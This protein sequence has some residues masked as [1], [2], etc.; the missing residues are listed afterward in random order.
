[1][2]SSKIIVI[3]LLSL[4][5][6]GLAFGATSGK[7]TGKVM[8]DD[9]KE[10]A[11]SAS[12]LILELKTGAKTDFEG[13]Y[14]ILNIPPGTYTLR[15]SYVGYASVKVNNVIVTSG[16]TFTQN[17]TLKPEAL[18]REEIVVKADPP[19][20]QLDVTGGDKTIRKQD[21][22]RTSANSVQD[23]IAKKAGVKVDHEG[24]LHV[25]GGRR[26]EVA[27][28]LDGID[29]RDP[30]VGRINDNVNLDADAISEIN[31]LT[32][33]FSPEYGQALSGI[34]NASFRE[35]DPEKYTAKAEYTSDQFNKKSSFGQ[36]RITLFVSGPIPGTRKAL[37]NPITFMVQAT[38]SQ[39]NTYLSYGIHREPNDYLGIGIKLPE[40][41]YNNYDLTSKFAYQFPPDKSGG[42]KKIT[43]TYTGS[44]SQWDLYPNGEANVSGDYG[45]RYKFNTENRPWARSN[46]NS[47]NVQFTNNLSS[48]T[49]Y[50]VSFTFQNSR[51]LVQ[52][53]NKTPG[54]FTLRS[55]VEDYEA[56]GQDLN[57]DG[58]PDGFVDAN[59]DGIYSGGGH[60]Y[61]DVN[62][63]GKWDRGE[64]W[65]DLNS[66]GVYDASET[67]TDLNSNG[68]WDVGE[69]FVDLN[70]NA[71]W[72]PAEPQLPEQD[73]N[74]NGHWDGERFQDADKDKKFTGWNW[75]DKNGNGKMDDGEQLWGNS[76]ERLDGDGYDDTNNDGKCNKKEL[77]ATSQDTPEPYID[78]DYFYDTGEP[79]ID[80]P[81]PVTGEYNGTRDDNEYWV[82]L[83]STNVGFGMIVDT[84]SHSLREPTLNGKYDD[85]DGQPDEYELF[86]Y[87]ATPSQLRADPTRPVIYTGRWDGDVANWPRK[88]G[89]LFPY[90]FVDRSNSGIASDTLR[91]TWIKRTT[92]NLDPKI[93]NPPT[94]SYVAGDP[95]TDYNKNGVWNGRD[96]FLNPGQWDESAIWQDRKS[97]EYSLKTTWQ[98]QIKHHELKAGVEAKYRDLQMQSISSPDMAYT[99]EV[100]LPAG[101]PWPDRGNTRDFYHYKP[102]EGAFYFNDKMEFEGLIVNAGIR[103]DFLITDP[104][105]RQQTKDAVSAGVP[106]AIVAQPGKAIFSP[107]LGIS[108]PITKTSKLFFNYGH[109]YQR[110]DFTNF[111]KSTTSNVASGSVV[112][113]PNL[114]YTKTVQ[115]ALGVQTELPNG[116]SFMIQGY[117]K[118]YFNLIGT[119]TEKYGPLTIDRYANKAYGRARGFEIELD[120]TIEN[121]ARE[122]DLRLNSSYDFSYTAGKSSTQDADALNRLNGVPANT[123]EYPLDWDERHRVNAS[124][125]LQFA[126]GRYPY[127]A[128]F[129][130]P[131]DDWFMSMEFQYGSGTPYTPSKYTTGLDPNLITANSA[132]YPWTENTNMRIEKYFRMG[133]KSVSNNRSNRVIFSVG[134]DIN[135][136]WNRRNIQGLY[137]E[138]GNPYQAIHPDD[139]NYNPFDAR[140]DYDANPRNFSA[141]RQILFR[142]GVSWE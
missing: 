115:Y 18:Q 103:N 64:D 102:I 81:D 120:H 52:P 35:G 114:D 37:K 9:T 32:D 101:S 123:E 75:V 132:R 2:R 124:F 119:Q 82:D 139:P 36:D 65:V 77:F 31:F 95:F 93:F 136:V 1:M 134:L 107:R 14:T 141:P 78:G 109:F 117:Y 106:G 54:E 130:I 113:N 100:P 98:S 47:V 73:W 46:R 80:Q 72:D 59:G 56:N 42:A 85:P 11:I 58:Y 3:V 15:F 39:T 20:V 27:M 125:G 40:K 99:G 126:E 84:S 79:F 105:L 17:A 88:N 121:I 110:P 68:V 63:N 60:G 48:K 22:E 7:I 28:L 118:D 19:K 13:N 89:R 44:F 8:L 87:P 86:C 23:I 41:Q 24:A 30:L 94:G 12:V 70:G 66:N 57:G 50:T 21:M 74:H 5:V 96:L 116:S 61:D 142:F 128:D 91:S 104:E 90:Y 62:K 97:V 25:R 138:T 83:P 111:F 10:G 76:G 16:V 26:G 33:G 51:T 34:A 133:A 112:G 129:K 55:Q 6:S 49:N 29:I 4:L 45:Y 108:H 71:R 131:V 140:Q 122:G 135:N 69:P 67:F 53:R 43:L 38:S 137:S 127:I 92:T